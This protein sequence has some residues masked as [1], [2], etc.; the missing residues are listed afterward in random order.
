MN[1]MLEM[2]E[3]HGDRY[4]L[5][6]HATAGARRDRVGGTHNNALR[7]SVTAPADKGRANQAIRRQLAEELKLKPVQVELSAGTTN[8]RKTFV[9]HEPPNDLPERVVRLAAI[10]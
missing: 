8:R 3:R 6:V 2:L 1:G 5:K 10:D 7:V 4:R 9:I